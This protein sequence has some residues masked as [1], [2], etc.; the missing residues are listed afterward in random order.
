MKEYTCQE[1]EII[2]ECWTKPTLESGT[3]NGDFDEEFI[4]TFLEN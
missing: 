2:K 4:Q 3:V 1:E